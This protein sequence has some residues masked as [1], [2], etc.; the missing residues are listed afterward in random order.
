MDPLYDE[1]YQKQIEDYEFIKQVESEQKYFDEQRELKLELEN[2]T[3]SELIKEYEV[4]EQP[5]VADAPQYDPEEKDRDKKKRIKKEKKAFNEGFHYVISQEDNYISDSRDSGKLSPSLSDEFDTP[6]RYENFSPNYVFDNYNKII[7][8]LR[9][10][11]AILT[12]NRQMQ[13]DPLQSVFTHA[14]KIQMANMQIRYEAAKKAYLSAMRALGYECDGETFQIIGEVSN[15][16]RDAALEKNI[17]DRRVIRDLGK[18]DEDADKSIIKRIEDSRKAAHISRGKKG[19]DKATADIERLKANYPESYQENQEIV[20]KIWTD[21]L[22]VYEKAKMLESAYETV[23]AEL[24]NHKDHGV[25]FMELSEETVERLQKIED[26]NNKKIDDLLGYYDNLKKTVTIVLSNGEHTDTSRLLLA[27]YK[28]GTQTEQMA[29]AYARAY[30]STTTDQIEVYLDKVAEF[31]S[32][33]LEEYNPEELIAH[34]EELA[35]LHKASVKVLEATEKD[36]ALYEQMGGKAVTILKCKLIRHYAEKARSFALFEARKEGSF[37]K[38]SYF[39]SEERAIMRKR[40][41]IGLGDEIDAVHLYLYLRERLELGEAEKEQAYNEFFKTEEIKE[42]YRFKLETGTDGFK[43]GKIID[44]I[45]STINLAKQMTGGDALEKNDLKTLYDQI[46]A[47]L[48]EGADEMKDAR[49]GTNGTHGTMDLINEKRKLESQ[50][51]NVEMFY[52]LTRANYTTAKGETIGEPI[53]RSFRNVESMYGFRDMS[54]EAFLDMCRKLSAGALSRDGATY[55]EKEEY[56]RENEEGLQIYKE[57]MREHYEKLEERFHHQVPSTEY[58]VQHKAELDGLFGNGQVDNH[59]MKKISL[60]KPQNEEDTYLYH[61]V[62][63]YFAIGT[64]LR[65]VGTMAA[66]DDYLDYRAAKARC[67]D[68]LEEAKESFMYLNE[69]EKYKN[70]RQ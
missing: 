23:M 54:D 16:E 32:K 33:E 36:N 51:R 70:A 41:G 43:H 11:K 60:M 55:E 40:F 61:L 68:T 22:R 66:N 37:L 27:R 58:M 39:T 63:V 24:E 42:K 12:L 53:F 62:Q 14:Q 5:I 38:Q 49:A 8:L 29:A 30:D 20:D 3:A 21:A 44:G 34:A 59:L 45:Y 18:L 64:Y 31:D 52:G 57:K 50:L 17:E 10:Y 6:L 26:V 13:E 56:Q 7:G 35:E 1:K 9:R 48:Y 65:Q 28:G 19:V 15:Q 25:T 69:R 47:K 2:M 67:A 4:Q 46:Y